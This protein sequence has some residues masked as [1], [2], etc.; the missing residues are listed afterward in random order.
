MTFQRIQDGLF[1]WTDTCNVYILKDGSS[2]LLIDLGDGSVLDH[3]GE[4]G[5]ERV[6]W[7]LFTHHHREQCQGAPRLKDR[8]VK[9]AAPE[10]ER[11]FF[12]RPASFRKMRPALGD[13]F[14]VHSSSYVRP[15]V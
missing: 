5:V 11:A 4:I 2:A 15:P 8:G 7:V 9:V 6:E 3:L 10:A 12:E 13:P 14:T 1:R